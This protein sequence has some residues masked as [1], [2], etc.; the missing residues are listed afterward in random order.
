MFQAPLRQ[1][2]SNFSYY[3][4]QT[5]AV[6]WML[7]KE[8]SGTTWED[9]HLR[10]GI[11]ADDMGL[12]KTIEVAGLLCENPKPTTLLVL[13]VALL[14]QWAAVLERAGLTVWIGEKERWILRHRLS[15]EKPAVFIVNYEKV[16]S[17]C[18][19]LVKGRYFD[20]IILDEAHRIR[21][22]TCTAAVV[23]A[24]VDA[25]TR[26]AVTGTPVVNSLKDAVSL[27]RFVGLSVADNTWHPSMYELANR[28]VLR[29]TMTTLQSC[30]ADAPPVPVV[31]ETVLDFATDEEASLYRKVQDSA[32]AHDDAP[33]SA[34]LGILRL[35][36]VSVHPQ[37]YIDAKKATNPY[38]SRGDWVLPATKFVA[39]TQLLQ[40]DA[41]A[42]APHKYLFICNFKAEI[43]LLAAHLRAEGL[44][45]HIFSYDGSMTKAAQ[46]AA[47][48]GAKAARGRTALLLQIHAGGVGLNLQ[49]FDRV[50]FLSNWW[51][52]AA[53]EQAI[54][55]AVRMGQKKVVQIHHLLLAEEMSENIDRRLVES[56]AKKRMI[57]E[58]FSAAAWDGITP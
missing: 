27:F 49:E 55:R 28:L 7:E 56:V 50:V 14:E 23:L 13:P 18:F 6:N 4:H 22:P 36:Q 51:T 35:R 11:L 34:I 5:I 9:Q 39:T 54:A 48:S 44:V 53:Q 15:A 25:E 57:A 58:K 8:L 52:A 21:S 31:H 29:R 47:I 24:T 12:G 40:A 42:A 17:S 33:A 41:A 37:I 10:G 46:D 2:W 32:V 1:L 19:S 20:R 45:E 3:Q 38:Y 16:Y 43:E 26:W 30:L